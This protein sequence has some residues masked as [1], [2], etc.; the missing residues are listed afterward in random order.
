MKTTL[1]SIAVLLINVGI[2]AQDKQ[3]NIELNKK[4]K[5]IPWYYEVPGKGVILAVPTINKGGKNSTASVS[6]DMYDNSLN[7]KWTAKHAPQANFS[8]MNL[9][10]FPWRY[11]VE[12]GSMNTNMSDQ[13]VWKANIDPSGK[14]MMNYDPISKTIYKIRMEDGAYSSAS[15]KN[16]ID[17]KGQF[18]INAFATK[19]YY[20]VVYK[21]QHFNWKSNK[22]SNVQVLRYD[23]ESFQEEHFTFE[24]PTPGKSKNNGGTRNWETIG[25]WNGKIYFLDSYA[26][27]AEDK[28][29]HKRIISV[30]MKGKVTLDKTIFLG[31]KIADGEHLGDI[32]FNR[33]DKGMIYTFS[34]SRKNGKNN[35]IFSCFDSGLKEIW[36]EE[37]PSGVSTGSV[38]MIMKRAKVEEVNNSIVI[39]AYYGLHQF[40]LEYKKDTKAFNFSKLKN[41]SDDCKD[42]PFK[43]RLECSDYIKLKKH[44]GVQTFLKT[45]FKKNSDQI[46]VQTFF[47][48]DRV[49]MVHKAEAYSNPN[50]DQFARMYMVKY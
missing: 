3:V 16:T 47:F 13:L 24:I 12:D 33:F 46:T 39:S 19:N 25:V 31:D 17:E 7:K 42:I 38:K 44:S 36:M 23:I 9:K 45:N 29:F 48:N 2:F 40:A 14:Y 32:M 30:D 22:I 49:I 20:Y 27:K 6:Y 35:V 4:L 18:T 43:Y 41:K 28:S 10:A 8:F 34:W 26:L 21:G 15:V 37:H 5:Q 11:R 50:P 1:F